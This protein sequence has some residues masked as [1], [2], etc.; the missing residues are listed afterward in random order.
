MLKGVLG[1]LALM[2][3]VGGLVMAFCHFL[4]MCILFWHYGWSPGFMTMEGFSGY[5][6]EYYFFGWIGIGIGRILGFLAQI[7]E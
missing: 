1:A 5:L 4:A 3:A 2:F 7:V 6:I